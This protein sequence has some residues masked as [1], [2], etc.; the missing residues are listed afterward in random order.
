MTCI[1]MLANS[2]INKKSY[3]L[4]DVETNVC[5]MIP[6]LSKIIDPFMNV[7]FL[8]NAHAKFFLGVVLFEGND[9]ILLNAS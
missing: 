6:K 9:E 3:I 1:H 2:S 7:S 5:K 4:D 8:H